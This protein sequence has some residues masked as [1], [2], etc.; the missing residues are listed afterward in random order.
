V[1]ELKARSALATTLVLVAASFLLVGVWSP[2]AYAACSFDKSN[3]HTVGSVF[4]GW[5]RTYCEISA[6]YTFSVETNHGHG[7]KYAALYHAD[8]SHLHCDS[9]ATGSV[10]A[11][12]SKSGINVN[13]LSFHDVAGSA[14]CYDRM[15]DGHGFDCHNME[16]LP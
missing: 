16:A 3:E 2:P 4:H 15:T 1:R 13:H 11:F 8:L 7:N 9:Y 6:D 12:C 5:S 10:N 14:S